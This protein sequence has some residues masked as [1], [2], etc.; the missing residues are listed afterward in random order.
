MPMADCILYLCD[1][2]MTH[3][4]LL[5]FI[6]KKEAGHIV[7]KFRCLSVGLMVCWSRGLGGGPHAVVHSRFQWRRVSCNRVFLFAPSTVGAFLTVLTQVD[8][9]VEAADDRSVPLAAFR[10]ASF[11][12]V[13]E[14]YVSRPYGHP[15]M[16]LQ[17]LLGVEPGLTAEALQVFALITFKRSL[18][19][20]IAG[21]AFL[22]Y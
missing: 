5:V 3:L 13:T 16:V 17:V 2:C 14:G 22:T 1:I 4:H 15:L 19:S 11:A 6:H 7:Q 21:V 18:F 20:A 9:A 10:I 8:F 12:T